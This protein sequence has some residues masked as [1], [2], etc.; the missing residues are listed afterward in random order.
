MRNDPDPVQ[1]IWIESEY[2][3]LIGYRGEFMERQWS[4]F[5]KKYLLAD[6]DLRR[7]LN[8]Q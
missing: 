1:I 2:E 5:D 6:S 8:A 4:I 3:T 7:L